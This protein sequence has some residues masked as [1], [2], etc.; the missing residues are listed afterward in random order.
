M[1]IA[2]PASETVPTMPCFTVSIATGLGAV[3]AAGAAGAAAALVGAAAAGFAAALVGALLP[4]VLVW[5]PQAR[6]A[7]TSSGNVAPRAARMRVPII[8]VAPLGR[9]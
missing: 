8:R 9:G 4:P 7:A 6:S 5:P 3:V 1:P 2:M